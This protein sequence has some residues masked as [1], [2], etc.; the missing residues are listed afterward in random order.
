[1]AFTYKYG[2]QDL[3]WYVIKDSSTLAVGEWCKS[4]DNAGYVARGTKEVAG[5]GFV[6]AIGK[7][8]GQLPP[9]KGDHTAGSTNT[10]DTTTVTT[11]AD[12]TTTRL[13]WALVDESILSVYSAQV[14]GTLGSTNGS[15]TVTGQRGGGI[16]VDSD[17]SNWGKVLET[18]HTRTLGDI[19]NFSVIGVDPDDTSRLL[20][21][22]A[23]PE[24]MSDQS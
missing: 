16:S 13:Y 18:T 4:Y 21:K 6:C 22:N 20:V 7:G 9:V 19:D 14:N 8:Q 10:S 24:W 17:G 3:H 12:N 5:T 15:P 1:M 11:A 23:M 2:L